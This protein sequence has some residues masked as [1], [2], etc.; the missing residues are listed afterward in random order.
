MRESNHRINKRTPAATHGR[1][2][3]VMYASGVG[4][5][6]GM[7]RF[8]KKFPK[9]LLRTTT[10]AHAQAFNRSRAESLLIWSVPETSRRRGRFGRLVLGHEALA[11]GAQSHVLPGLLGE[12][13]ALVVVE[14]GFL[15]DPPDHAR[16]EEIFAVK[17]LD[18][19]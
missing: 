16:A 10:T 12:A 7:P 3:T 14:D 13:S 6:V 18:K 19:F 4:S 11:L 5:S 9:T 17:L 2:K 15:H 1:N 8:M